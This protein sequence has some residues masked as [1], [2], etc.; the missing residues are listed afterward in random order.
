MTVTMGKQYRTQC[1][2]VNVVA[3]KMQPVII[4][5]I[6]SEKDIREEM[7]KM[8]NELKR[9]SQKPQNYLKVEMRKLKA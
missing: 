6:I 3:L 7:F 1:E 4:T 9:N 8:F 2:W 5:K